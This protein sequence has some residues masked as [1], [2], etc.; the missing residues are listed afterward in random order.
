MGD[1]FWSITVE[2]S[3]REVELMERH[4]GGQETG[5]GFRRMSKKRTGS[6]RDFKTIYTLL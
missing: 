6:S 5:F 2:C 3:I 1:V 4:T